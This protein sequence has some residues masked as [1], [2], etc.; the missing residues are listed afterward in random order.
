MKSRLKF[1]AV[2]FV[3]MVF[4]SYGKPHAVTFETAANAGDAV[5]ITVGGVKADMIYANNSDSVTFPADNA[6]MDQDYDDGTATI[7]SKFF[8]GKTEVTYAL[9]IKVYNWATNSKDR[10]ANVYHFANNGFQY[11]ESSIIGAAAARKPVIWINWRDAMVWCNALTEY[12][13][14]QN[15]SES[16]IDC[17]YY[18]DYGSIIRDSRFNAAACDGAIANA[19]AKGFRLPTSMEWEYAARYRGSDTTNTVAGYTNPY[20]TRG[21]S[22]SGAA[23]DYTNAAATSAAAVYAATQ[24]SEAMSRGASGANR[25]GLYD[26][27]GN[28]LEWCFDWHPSNTGTRRVIRGGGWLSGAASL[29]VG[30]VYHGLPGSKAQDTGFRFARTK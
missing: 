13:N 22:A 15:G 21:N 10:G 30:R 11:N 24:T 17:V 5:T 8:I 27:S 9:W 23:S 12:Y 2:L 25:L 4:T 18:T 6:D 20:Y 28:V 14:E 19:D 3:F 7:T 26:M 16:D 1:A 29:Q